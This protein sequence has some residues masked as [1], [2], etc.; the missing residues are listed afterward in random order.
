MSNQDHKSSDYQYLEKLKF[1]P[2][3]RNSFLNF[4]VTNFRVVLLLIM[5]L[6]ALGVYSYIEL[7]VESDPEV[8]I[9]IAVVT[10][11]FPGASSAD[12]EEL[13]TKKVETEIAGLKDIDRITSSSSNS[14]SSVT[15]EFNADAD[16]DD[17]IR[18]LRDAANNVKDDLPDDANDPLVNEIS[19]DDTPIFSVSIAGPYDGF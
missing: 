7:P 2:E 9:P 10:T 5:L 11:V 8:K 16:L 3:L 13:V 4:F 6:T 12:M 19:V 1:R 14:I 17:S 18:R 15:V